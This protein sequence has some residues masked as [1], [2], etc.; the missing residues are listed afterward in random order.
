MLRF[1]LYR[2][3]HPG[4]HLRVSRLD[5]V[6]SR[7]LSEA[8]FAFLAARHT[9]ELTRETEYRQGGPPSCCHHAILRI[10]QCDWDKVDDR[11]HR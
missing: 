9:A 4:R 1:G 5:I 2:D 6:R 10:P 11:R 8:D 3:K 7:L